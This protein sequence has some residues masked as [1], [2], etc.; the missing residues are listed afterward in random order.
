MEISLIDEMIL[1][2]TMERLRGEGIGLPK[3]QQGS[4]PREP[5]IKKRPIQIMLYPI[6]L[7]WPSEER[8]STIMQE[9]EDSALKKRAKKKGPGKGIRGRLQTFLRDFIGEES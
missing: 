6:N 1:A 4:R 8:Q 2:S 3:Y 5:S 7:P 9:G